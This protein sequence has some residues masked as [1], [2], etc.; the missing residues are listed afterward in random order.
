M[1]TRL[2]TDQKLP[3]S[4]PGRLVSFSVLLVKTFEAEKKKQE[5][6]KVENKKAL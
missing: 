3:G 1:E 6:K 5:K 4:T 2:T